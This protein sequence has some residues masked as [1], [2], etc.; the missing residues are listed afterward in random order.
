MAI[1]GAETSISPKNILY[2]TDFSHASKAALPFAR[3]LAGNY[4]STLIALHVLIPPQ[5]C[6]DSELRTLLVEEGAELAQLEMRDLDSRITGIAHQILIDRGSKV[7]PS[8]EQAI[9]DHDV[10]LIVLGTH[11]W[12][13]IQKNL[14]GSV[15]EEI[16]R[17]SP[18]P[19][20][21]IGPAVYGSA[22]ADARFRRVLLATDFE[23]GSHT[24]VPCAMSLAQG[25]WGK[26]IL[27]HVINDSERK[28]ELIIGP[29]VAEAMHELYELIPEHSQFRDRSEAIVRYGEPAKQIIETAQQRCADLIV[30]GV[31]DHANNLDI[32]THREKTTAHKVVVHAA[33]PVL[34]VRDTDRKKWFN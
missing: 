21:T 20:L 28:G 1:I 14:L 23:H 15:A 34:T 29:S 6:A 30:L 18:V 13:G 3:A 25:N 22:G 10:N 33:C 11:G 24:A 17:C 5:H 27:L 19:V 7:W 31:H 32:A 26:L 16:F 12:V 9:K 8:V 2:V 4:G